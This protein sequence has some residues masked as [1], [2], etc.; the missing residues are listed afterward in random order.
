[1][2]TNMHVYCEKGERW[3][4]DWPAHTSHFETEL[5]EDVKKFKGGK[6]GVRFPGGR[7][8]FFRL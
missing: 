1:M 3:D 5:G 6:K 8:C 7:I 2:K 4:V